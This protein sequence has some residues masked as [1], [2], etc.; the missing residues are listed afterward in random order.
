MRILRIILLS[1]TALVVATIPARAT[2][3]SDYA[4]NAALTSLLGTGTY[5]VA[6]HT[7]DPGETCAT[8]ELAAANGY[9]RQ[10]SAYAVTA[11]IADNDTALSF[12]PATADQGTVTHFSV[13]DAVTAGN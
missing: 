9:A 6:L 10:G 7:A 8:A 5:Y 11:S 3:L 4:E 12:G 2:D 1:L 13:W